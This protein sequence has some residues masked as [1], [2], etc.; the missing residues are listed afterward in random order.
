MI[1]EVM[2]GSRDFLWVVDSNLPSK[3]TRDRIMMITPFCISMR[4][5]NMNISFA[6]RWRENWGSRTETLVK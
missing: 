6:I 1:L 2:G 3:F 5:M 4:T